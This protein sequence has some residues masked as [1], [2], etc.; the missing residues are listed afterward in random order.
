MF[1]CKDSDYITDAYSDAL[2]LCIPL[3]NCAWVWVHATCTTDP[4]ACVSF[5]VRHVSVH[6]VMRTLCVLTQRLMSRQPPHPDTDERQYMDSGYLIRAFTRRRHDM[7]LSVCPRSETSLCSL[8]NL[9]CAGF[10]PR[11]LP[12]GPD[13]LASK[14]VMGRGEEAKFNHYS[15]HDRSTNAAIQERV[16][17]KQSMFLCACASRVLLSH[18]HFLKIILP[19]KRYFYTSEGFCHRNVVSLRLSSQVETQHV[20]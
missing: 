1:C 11:P 20:I 9:W 5:W 6:G 13:R 16:S 14:D 12:P 2:D 7:L 10:S 17:L 4:F 18:E 3:C 19:G 15:S 8:L